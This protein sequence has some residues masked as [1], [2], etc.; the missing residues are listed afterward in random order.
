MPLYEPPPLMPHW[1]LRLAHVTLAAAMLAGIIAAMFCVASL[2]H[3]VV[4]A[5]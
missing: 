3:A 5:L 2:L 1:L 4:A